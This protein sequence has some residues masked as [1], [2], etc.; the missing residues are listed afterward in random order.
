MPGRCPPQGGGGGGEH[1]ARL[2]VDGLPGEPG[3]PGQS[4]NSGISGNSGLPGFSGKT[5]NPGIRRLRAA[6]LGVLHKG[7]DMER[8]RPA[9]KESVRQHHARLL[10]AAVDGV[11]QVAL[12]QLLVVNP[13][14][15]VVEALAAPAQRVLLEPDVQHVV[16]VHRSFCHRHGRHGAAADL[17]GGVVHLQGP[18]HGAESLLVG[19]DEEVQRGHVHLVGRELEADVHGPAHPAGELHLGLEQGA[20]RLLRLGAR[21]VDESRL[22]AHAPQSLPAVSHHR[23][24]L[25]VEAPKESFCLFGSR[26]K[27]LILNV[28][29]TAK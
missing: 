11:A 5:G 9:G 25:T 23:A 20:V 2:R 22:R 15:Y 28:F 7:I 17:Q 13:K 18:V 27:C 21:V 29:K 10:H 26:R 16:P 4:G 8:R 12:L 1:L 6:P 24:E 3:N 19:L 14:V